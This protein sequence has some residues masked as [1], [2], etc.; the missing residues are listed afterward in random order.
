MFKRIAAIGFIFLCTS[1]AWAILGS[2]V[3]YRTYSLEP[4]LRGRVASTWGA[5][6][7]QAAP[8]ATYLVGSVHQ[9]TVTKDGKDVTRTVDDR[10]ITP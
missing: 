3:F 2:T 8:T 6:Q 5:P 9:V 1:L 4:E 10:N 7:E